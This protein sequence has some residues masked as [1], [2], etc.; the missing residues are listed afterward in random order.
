MKHLIVQFFTKSS[1]ELPVP[2]LMGTKNVDVESRRYNNNISNP[3]IIISTT[4]ILKSSIKRL[5]KATR[6]ISK[7][8]FTGHDC[9]MEKLI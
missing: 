1:K 7:L 4:G 3:K 8:F 9:K 5:N 6:V 2:Y